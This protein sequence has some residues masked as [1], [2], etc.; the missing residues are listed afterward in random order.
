MTGRWAGLFLKVCFGRNVFHRPVCRARLAV[1]ATAA[2][3]T[4]PSPVPP[5][6]RGVIYYRDMTETVALQELYCVEP[7]TA[8]ARAE[9]V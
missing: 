5:T 1:F 7:P 3:K 4:L 9:Y 2:R 8:R 6:G